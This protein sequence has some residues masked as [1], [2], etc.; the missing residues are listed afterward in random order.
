[1]Q[2]SALAIAVDFVVAVV[3]VRFGAA[4]VIGYSTRPL[5]GPM[6]VCHAVAGLFMLLPLG[7]FAGARVI[8]VIGVCLAV[9]LLASNRLA[10][11]AAS[12]A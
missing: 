5:G 6:R 11:R 3:G 4:G 9:A 7:A 12:T 8:N 1:M 10:R 2:G